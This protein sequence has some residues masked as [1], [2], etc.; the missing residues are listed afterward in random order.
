MVTEERSERITALRRW[1]GAPVDASGVAAL[2]VLFGLVMLASSVRFVARGWVDSLLLEPRFHFAYPGLAW[3]APSSAP[4]VYAC[5]A[6]MMLGALGLALG[7]WQRASALSFFVGFTAVELTDR[8]YYLNHYY[9]VSLLAALCCVLPLS[10]VLSLDAW[11]AR[12][13]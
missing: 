11:R 10:R 6:L 1:L 4:A 5:F 2:R 13:R 3:A 7:L 8:A 12:R 9:L